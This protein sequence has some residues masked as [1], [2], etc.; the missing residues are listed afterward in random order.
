M[1][2]SNEKNKKKKRKKRKSQETS[3]A[4]TRADDLPSQTNESSDQRLTI[5]IIPPQPSTTTKNRLPA[6]GSFASTSSQLHSARPPS[7]LS[8]AVMI[9]RPSSALSHAAQSEGNRSGSASEAQ[10]LEPWAV[11][12]SGRFWG[13]DDRSSHFPRRGGARGNFHNRGG[14]SHSRGSIRNR[15]GFRA[16]WHPASITP[17][18]T[19]LTNSLSHRPETPAGQSDTGRSAGSGAG[20][21][22]VPSKQKNFTG[23]S[24]HHNS[25]TNS[26]RHQ[27][28]PV[29]D[30]EWRHDGWE[31]IEREADGRHLHSSHRGRAGSS[32]NH[33]SRGGGGWRGGAPV[34]QPRRATPPPNLSKSYS[35]RPLDLPSTHP[36]P[37]PELRADD[38]TKPPAVSSAQDDPKSD[39]SNVILNQT[40]VASLPQAQPPPNPNEKPVVRVI[41]REGIKTQGASSRVEHVS[42][43]KES[44]SLSRSNSPPEETNPI[45]V[46]LPKAI[47]IGT[48]PVYPPSASKSVVNQKHE[49]VSK[50]S[51]TLSSLTDRREARVRS[52]GPSSSTPELSDNTAQVSQS[53]STLEDQTSQSSDPDLRSFNLV[54]SSLPGAI[55]LGSIGGA[56]VL[57]EAMSTPKHLMPSHPVYQNPNLQSRVEPSIA[58]TNPMGHSRTSSDNSHAPPPGPFGPRHHSDFV[59]PNTQPPPPPPPVPLPPLN[60]GHPPPHS[61]TSYPNPVAAQLLPLPPPLP[62]P[63][64]SAI[65]HPGNFYQPPLP[66]IPPSHYFDH[67]HNMPYPHP[68]SLGPPPPLSTSNATGHV[69]GAGYLPPPPPLQLP[70]S[71]LGPPRSHPA[72]IYHQPPP[73]PL[74]TLTQQ[75][76]PP[77]EPPL[78]SIS[79]P[80][81]SSASGLNPGMMMMGHFAPPK[82]TKV[83]ISNPGGPKANEEPIRFSK[84]RTPPMG[85]E[86]K[87]TENGISYYEYNGVTYFGDSLPPSCLPSA[88][89]RSHSSAGDDE[90]EDSTQGHGG[91]QEEIQPDRFLG[92]PLSSHHD[93][94]HL[95]PSHH[96]HPS[97]HDHHLNFLS[98]N[99][100]SHPHYPHLI[101]GF[102]HHEVPNGHL[103]NGFHP[104]H[105]PTTNGHQG[106]P[107]VNGMTG[108]P[109]VQPTESPNGID[110]AAVSRHRLNGSMTTGGQVVLSQVIKP[111]GIPFG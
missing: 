94:H 12:R 109:V 32:A 66:S 29:D 108:S 56:E 76:R 69:Y 20:W 22:T 48:I 63:P 60:F 99:S 77:F 67:H 100:S 97:L 52:T 41:P 80:P 47:K 8:G 73:P 84:P 18:R 72:P 68:P 24:Q 87:M 54:E 91:A 103:A 98:N 15:G 37:S 45:I 50:S 83:R 93:Y 86:I 7:S 70:P 89:L 64:I 26:H 75:P 28:H 78:S 59:E 10:S 79:L 81:S 65:H 38:R 33:K 42:E 25:Q 110:P 9:N 71:Q 88:G 13:H 35:E 53:S 23:A 44:S 46:K 62:P 96:Y 39:K 34:S 30:G 105:H 90:A 6:E 14:A 61:P 85:S 106:P 3:I 36:T 2:D 74:L 95:D 102:H 27:A 19:S 101:A 17:K 111:L 92:A 51:Q 104:H 21:I 1:V 31:E 82:S 55:T 107:S 16:D 57:R 40:C 5:K 58:M 4:R 43:T 11:P 49:R